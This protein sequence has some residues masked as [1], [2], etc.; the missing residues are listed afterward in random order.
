MATILAL[1][2]NL[3]DKN[4]HLG[5][6]IKRIRKKKGLSQTDLANKMG[7]RQPTISDIENGRGTLDSF[8]KIIQALN[9][10]LSLSY[11]DE[12]QNQDNEISAMIDMLDT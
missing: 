11:G 2:S 12:T 1:G 6:A 9:I 5:L 3:G 8:L 10:N 7:M 4:S